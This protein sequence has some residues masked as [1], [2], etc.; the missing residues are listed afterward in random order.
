MEK[1]SLRSSLLLTINWTWPWNYSDFRL[2]HFDRGELSVNNRICYA[3]DVILDTRLKFDTNV[4][5]KFVF[6]EI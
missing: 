2:Y 5:D 6:R 3:R 1:T 4:S